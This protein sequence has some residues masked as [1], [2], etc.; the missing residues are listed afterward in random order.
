MNTKVMIIVG[1]SAVIVAML[2]YC[3]FIKHESG[4]QDIVSF[5][6]LPITEEQILGKEIR[7]GSNG[8][9]NLIL[10]VER[11]THLERYPLIDKAL[12][13]G[14]SVYADLITLINEH[15]MSIDEVEIRFYFIEHSIRESLCT[16]FVESDRVYIITGN[17]NTTIIYAWFPKGVVLPRDYRA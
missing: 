6:R 11:N 12:Y 4:K 10:Y 1:I 17:S 8:S 2:I 14:S 15:N 16:W 3:L 9:T 13:E 5:L 7:A